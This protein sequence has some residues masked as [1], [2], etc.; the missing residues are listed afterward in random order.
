[1]LL[2]RLILERRLV[3]KIYVPSNGRKRKQK[4]RI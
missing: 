1:M 4:K 2:L 3:F